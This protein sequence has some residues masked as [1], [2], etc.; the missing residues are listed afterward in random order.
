MTKFFSFIDHLTV[1][2]QT[3]ITSADYFK[4]IKKKRFVKNVSFMNFWFMEQRN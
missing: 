4:V 1:D 2:R 3:D